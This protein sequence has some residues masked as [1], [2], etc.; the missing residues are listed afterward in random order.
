MK[1]ATRD[2]AKWVAEIPGREK[3]ELKYEHGLISL[4]EYIL[5]LMDIKRKTEM[6]KGKTEMKVIDIFFVE[7]NP[8][9]GCSNGEFEV[10]RAI[11]DTGFVHEGCT[12]R[13]GN[14]CAG[15]DRLPKI[16]MSFRDVSEFEEYISE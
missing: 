12:C 10:Y 2:F 15:T 5:T 4:E 16:G 9:V 6:E 7:E 8:N 13:C 3:V 11:F 14:G 1:M